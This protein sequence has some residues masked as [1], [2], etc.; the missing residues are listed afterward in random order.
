MLVAIHTFSL[1][2]CLFI[3]FAH[4][5]IGLFVLLVTCKSS[6]YRSFVKYVFCKHCLPGCSLPF[7]FHDSVVGFFC[8]FFMTVF[9]E[10][11][12]LFYLDEVQFNGLL[13]FIFC[14]FCIIVKESLQNPSH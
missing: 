10:E 14:A 11:Q 6:R 5:L 2:K 3:Y 9:F 13:N 8:C 7:H 12:E 4:L 1:V